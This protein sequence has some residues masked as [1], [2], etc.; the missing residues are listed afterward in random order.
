M[1]T[2]HQRLR[3]AEAVFRRLFQDDFNG[4]TE[5][6]AGSPPEFVPF[7]SASREDAEKEISAEIDLNLRRVGLAIEQ[8]N[9]KSLAELKAAFIL[10][11]AYIQ[12][13]ETYLSIHADD[14]SDR[15][16]LV[17]QIIFALIERKKLLLERYSALMT[18]EKIREIKTILGTLD[19]K[20]VR[21]AIEKNLVQLAIKDQFILEEFRG[22]EKFYMLTLP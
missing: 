21:K 19:D 17:V 12:K 9:Q 10:L 8:I 7:K 6:E 2:T 14:E 18:Q 3:E 22:L 15:K 20:A 16:S 1:S 13:P 11:N 4:D 5:N